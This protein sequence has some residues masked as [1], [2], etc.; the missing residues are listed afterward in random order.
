MG[1]Q[2]LLAAK[3]LRDCGHE[4]SCVSRSYYAAYA[5]ATCAVLGVGMGVA[6]G[7]RSNPG[8]R[9]L[10]RLLEGSLRARGLP[11]YKCRDLAQRLRTLFR[12]RV[13][14]DYDPLAHVDRV[15]SVNCIRDAAMIH[16]ALREENT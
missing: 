15:T 13:M 5:H 3:L 16:D 6:R 9:Q 11:A 7:G 1:G 8:H 2:N 12:L 4:R 14:A 10:G